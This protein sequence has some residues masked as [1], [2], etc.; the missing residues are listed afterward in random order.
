MFFSI[1]IKH[2]RF[3]YGA[4]VP[5]ERRQKDGALWKTR[6]AVEFRGRLITV[7]FADRLKLR[8]S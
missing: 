7:M 8:G 5:A 2:H 4:V 3:I 6:R 1:I